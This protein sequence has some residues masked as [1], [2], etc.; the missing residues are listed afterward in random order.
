MQNKNIFLAATLFFSNIVAEANS[1]VPG[2][3]TDSLPTVA[4]TNSSITILNG[5]RASTVAALATVKEEKKEFIATVLIPHN[6]EA[7]EQKAQ[8][9]AVVQGG[10]D[11][12]SAASVAAYNRKIAPLNT[13]GEEIDARKKRLDPVWLDINIKEEDYTKKIEELES[14]IKELIR[15]YRPNCLDNGDYQIESLVN[16]WGM[17]FDGEGK[18]DP[19]G[20]VVPGG[21]RV[22]PNGAPPVF[23]ELTKEYKERYKLDNKPGPKAP[24]TTPP[25]KG[26]LE[27]ATDKALEY[28]RN[29]INSNDRFKTRRTTAVLA[30]RG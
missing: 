25:Q 26:T 29:L 6:T 16:C 30:V 17:Y 18:R 12:N 22:Y 8:L 3:N 20:V 15:K 7:A 24:E 1:G 2:R 13:W 23:T 10:F 21:I 27:K 4:A 9:A 28:F 14:R 19:L 11:P 5:D